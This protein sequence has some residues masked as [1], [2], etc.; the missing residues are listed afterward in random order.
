MVSNYLE[1]DL[2][3]WIPQGILMEQVR[4]IK[5][6]GVLSPDDFQQLMD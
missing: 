1:N 3:S 2:F 6:P 4:S 5:S